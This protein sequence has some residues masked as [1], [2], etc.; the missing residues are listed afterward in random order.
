[1]PTSGTGSC[2]SSAAPATQAGFSLLELLVVVAIIGL[3]VGAVTLSWGMWR[4][5]EE[6]ARE[7]MRKRSGERP[8]PVE[9]AALER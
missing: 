7:W 1:M 5:V 3:L 8:K 6:P 2:S 4:F 9:E